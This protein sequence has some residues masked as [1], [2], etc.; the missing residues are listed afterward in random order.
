[1]YLDFDAW[2]KPNSILQYYDSH[3]VQIWMKTEFTDGE[4]HTECCNGRRGSKCTWE[5]NCNWWTDAVNLHSAKP[6]AGSSVVIPKGGV[7]DA[8]CNVTG[9]NISKKNM[10]GIYFYNG[11]T[12]EWDNANA[13]EVGMLD[14]NRYISVDYTSTLGNRYV[15]I[16]KATFRLT[17]KPEVNDYPTA[18]IKMMVTLKP[19]YDLA[20]S[21]NETSY[22]NRSSYTYNVYVANVEGTGVYVQ[23]PPDNGDITKWMVT[24]NGKEQQVELDKEITISAPSEVTVTFSAEKTNDVISYYKVTINGQSYYWNNTYHCWK[25]ITQ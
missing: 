24:V 11:I 15:L 9:Y 10:I 8:A 25:P 12:E 18:P 23:G 14:L 22:I 3:Q 6:L 13:S 17:A 4:D 7:Y 20:V 19:M 16:P 21:K 2:N 1:M 5:N